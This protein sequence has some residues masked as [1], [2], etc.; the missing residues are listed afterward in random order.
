[1]RVTVEV[2][3]PESGFVLMFRVSNGL[4]PPFVKEQCIYCQ[5]RRDLFSYRE[6]VQRN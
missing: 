5:C 1:M 4:E 3:F 2:A 6:R